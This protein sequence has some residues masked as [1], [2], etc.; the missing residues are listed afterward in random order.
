M[1]LSGSDR[2]YIV[3]KLKTTPPIDPVWVRFEVLEWDA[4]KRARTMTAELTPT[5]VTS[6]KN[7]EEVIARFCV[8]EPG[9]LPKNGGTF[10]PDLEKVARICEPCRT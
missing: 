7:V 2:K 6:R 8:L 5:E 3:T 1:K 10:R 4:G 9:D